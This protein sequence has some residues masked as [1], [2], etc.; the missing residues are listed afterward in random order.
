MTDMYHIHCCYELGVGTV[1]FT[2]IPCNCSACS[3]TLRKGWVNDLKANDQPRFQP[4]PDC[5]YKKV[6]GDTNR[7]YI[8]KL[9]PRQAGDMTYHKFQD[10][11]GDLFCEGIRDHI[12]AIVS[13]D[14]TVG[15]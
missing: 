11:D 8:T 13:E 2:R 5:K 7:W 15:R 6:L 12:C 3:K 1:A 14:I 10:D 4:V 9:E